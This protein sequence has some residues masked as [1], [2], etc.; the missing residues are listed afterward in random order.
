MRI[1]TNRLQPGMV[2]LTGEVV[3]KVQRD[4]TNSKAIFVTLKNPKTGKTRTTSWNYGGTVSVK[5]PE[6]KNESFEDY[7]ARMDQING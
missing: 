6:K 1:Q 4:H 2:M 3:E 5:D 7:V